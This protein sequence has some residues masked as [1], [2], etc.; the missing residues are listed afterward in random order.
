MYCHGGDYIVLTYDR[1]LKKAWVGLIVYTLSAV[2]GALLGFRYGR[3]D[4]G[5]TPSVTSVSDFFLEYYSYLKYNF[6]IFFTGFTIYSPVACIIV[7]IWCGIRMGNIIRLGNI[8]AAVFEILI[9]IIAVFVSVIAT[10]QY[11]SLKNAVPNFFEL[12]SQ[13]RTRTF[14]LN[15]LVLSG[16]LLLVLL[17]KNLTLLLI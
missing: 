1:N 10:G 2:L 3:F 17:I 6:I 15:F 5:I 12:L 7:L 4:C 11:I 9:L 8:A 13:E 16:L 14:I